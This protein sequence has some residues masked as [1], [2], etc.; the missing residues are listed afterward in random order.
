MDPSHIR[1]SI[2]LVDFMLNRGNI[3]YIC[4]EDGYG[5]TGD[6]LATIEIVIKVILL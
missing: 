5:D 3:Y 1:T 4:C 2:I 6:I